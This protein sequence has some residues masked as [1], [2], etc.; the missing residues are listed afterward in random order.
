MAKTHHPTIKYKDPNDYTKQDL[1]S[2][3]LYFDKNRN[4]MLKQKKWIF[5]NMKK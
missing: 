3:T 1:K 4:Q 2:N 5:E